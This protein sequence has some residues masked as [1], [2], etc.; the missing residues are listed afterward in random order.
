MTKNHLRPP[1]YQQFARSF[2]APVGFAFGLFTAASSI[3][4]SS[5]RTY[6]PLRGTA[7][8]SSS[9]ARA[10][11]ALLVVVGVVALVAML[12]A[13]WQRPDNEPGSASSVGTTA[14]AGEPQPLAA[15]RRPTT[16][17]PREFAIAYAR[18]IWTYDTARH[19]YVDWQNAMSVFADPTSAAPD[20]AKS[21]LPQWAEWN[22]LQLHKAHATAASITAVVTPELQ[23]MGNG[24][25][26]PNGWHAY[27]LHGKQAVVMDT[28]TRVLDRQAAVAV[29]CT[30]ICR[31]WS[32]TSQVSQ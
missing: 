4:R 5:R 24:G 10:V 23:A 13:G 15:W 8:K 12:V 16:T 28:G 1:A 18:A 19:G 9:R 11:A 21:L 22:Q 31:F 25:D 20:V 27:V 2:R 26:V 6:V 29:V 17:E 32:A 3:A 14:P 7:V 30:P